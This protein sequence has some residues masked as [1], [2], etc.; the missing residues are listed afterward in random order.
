M[1]DSGI[2]ALSQVHMIVDGLDHPES[3]TVSPDCIIWAGG[4]AGQVYRVDPNTGTAQVVGSTG[5]F[6]LGITHDGGQHVYVCDIKQRAVL[7][8]NVE[9]GAVETVCTD[10]QGRPLIN[11]NHA[12]F[13]PQGR[14]YVTDSGHWHADDGYLFTIDP[15]GTARIVDERPRH[16][17]N[18]LFL[19]FEQGELYIAEST[20]PG[21]TKLRLRDNAFETLAELSGMVPD[22]LALDRDRNVYVGCYRP[23][24]IVRIS[25]HG[26]EIVVSD[27]EGT[28]IAAPTNVA[29]GGHDGRTLYIA[30]LGRWHIGAIHVE[31]SGL[32]LWY[33]ARSS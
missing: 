5:G 30:S 7:R 3:V 23:D 12:V 22:G 31:V 1:V 28:V 13:D 4:E 17:P 2:I 15:D 8:M 27:P 6:L 20:M 24:M 9:N 19:D 16:F 33:P 21:I 29:F 11:P 14:M 18:G 10:V 25:R 26:V 32:P